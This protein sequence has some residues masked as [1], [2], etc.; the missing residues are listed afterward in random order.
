[1]FETMKQYNNETISVLIL[2]LFSSMIPLSEPT[3]KGNE[4]NYIKEC[5]DTGWVSSVGKFV[6]EFENK[7]AAYTGARY[8]IATVN[9][10]AA[11]HVSLVALG[12]Q[13]HDEIIVPTLTFIAPVNAV[14]YCNALPLFF[15][16][17]KDTLCID[18]ASVQ[19]FLETETTQ[20]NTGYIYNKKT[21]NRIFGIIPVH[22]AGHP[23]DMEEILYLS[24]KYNLTV[25]EDAAESIGSLYTNKH[26]GTFGKLG[27]LSFNCN[28]IITTGGGGM[29][30]TDDEGLAKMVRHLT[31]QAKKDGLEYI[32]DAVGY[33]YRLTNIQAA[34]G[35]AQM[36]QLEGFVEKKRKNFERYQSL[37]QEID[38]ISLMQ[39]CTGVKSN[40]WLY[41]LRV[42]KEDKNP[43]IHYLISKDIQVRPV[44]T[45]VHTFDMYKNHAAYEIKNAFDIHDTCI[46]IPSSV[47]LTHVEIDTVT[48]EIKKYF[49]YEKKR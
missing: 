34:L 9:G 47:D 44:W 46:H 5:L 26:T 16:A 18:V 23:A 49:H 36:E 40:K 15:D 1:M 21:G 27:C 7:V 20:K 39:E 22:I 19:K 28:K 8:A 24:Q 17:N 33:N 10:T 38:N 42:P 30:L 25:V 29:V 48:Q 45:P 41:T 43:L 37:L 35:V 32:H 6:S 11:L 3:F 14:T 4:W 31:T 13:P 2:S 12:I